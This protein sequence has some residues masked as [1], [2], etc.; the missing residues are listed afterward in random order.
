MRR[1]HGGEEEDDDGL[2]REAGMRWAGTRRSQRDTTLVS[3]SV[4]SA[5]GVEHKGPDSVEGSS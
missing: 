3:G 4:R 2:E 5:Y 1:W